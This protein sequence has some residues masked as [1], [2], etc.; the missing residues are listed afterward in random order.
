MR[1]PRYVCDDGNRSWFAIA[2]TTRYRPSGSACAS[3]ARN[4]SSATRCAASRA[5]P[6]AV[7]VIRTT[8]CRTSALIAATS[9]CVS[10][11]PVRSLSST[12]ALKSAGCWLVK[13]S[14]T[15]A[16]S[17]ACSSGAA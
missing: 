16:R 14:S 11:S 1:E 9:Y 2:L 15:P 6:S 8:A 12:L 5:A 10:S 4:R 3:T 17:P 13:N 7:C